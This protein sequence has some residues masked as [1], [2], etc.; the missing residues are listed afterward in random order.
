MTPCI[1]SAKTTRD[2]LCKVVLLYSTLLY[3]TY[4]ERR[5]GMRQGRAM[6]DVDSKSR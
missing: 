5:E 3:L 4:Y 1:S 6:K 2:I